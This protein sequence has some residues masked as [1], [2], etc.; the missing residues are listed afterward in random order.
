MATVAAAPVLAQ[1]ES[2]L[3][4]RVRGSAQ[5]REAPAVSR[6]AAVTVLERPVRL[7]AA[8]RQ[9]VP[10]LSQLISTDQAIVAE[11]RSRLDGGTFAA[12]QTAVARSVVTLPLDAIDPRLQTLMRQAAAQES[13]L[14]PEPSRTMLDDRD[15]WAGLMALGM[16][17]GQMLA[18][19][20]LRDRLTADLPELL[21][22]LEP[23]PVIAG[24][25]QRRRQARQQL[26]EARAEAA[27]LQLTSQLRL[28][29]RSVAEQDQVRREL[30]DALGVDERLARWRA[31]TGAQAAPARVWSSL[32]ELLAQRVRQLE[33][34]AQSIPGGAQAWT[35]HSRLLAPAGPGASR[36]G[37][38]RTEWR[39]LQADLRRAVREGA[40]AM[41]RLEPRL[42]ER[43]RL[44]VELSRQRS[45]GFGDGL[46]EVVEI[47]SQLLNWFTAAWR[48]ARGANEPSVVNA[49]DALVRRYEQ[50]SD[51]ALALEA[52]ADVEWQMLHASSVVSRLGADAGSQSGAAPLARLS[53]ALATLAPELAA[54]GK[55]VDDAE[56][57]WLRFDDF[58]D[59]LLLARTRV[60]DERQRAWPAAEAG[61]GLGSVVGVASGLRAVVAV[62]AADA[63]ADQQLRA[64]T[65]LAGAQ[66]PV[67]R[68]LW[69]RPTG[70]GW[71]Y[72]LPMAEF[73]EQ[74]LREIDA[75]Q[76][77]DGYLRTASDP[78]Q[79]GGLRAGAVISLVDLLGLAWHV[80]ADGDDLALLVDLNGATLAISDLGR[81]RPRLELRP[82]APHAERLVRVA[83][84]SL[85]GLRLIEVQQPGGFSAY[86]E[87]WTGNLGNQMSKNRLSYALITGV[88]VI[89]G[90]IAVAVFSAPLAAVA[91]A[92]ATALAFQF[93]K[94]E[95]FATAHTYV[96]RVHATPEAQRAAAGRLEAAEFLSNIGT[97]LWG[98]GHALLNVR[99]AVLTARAVDAARQLATAEPAAGA[100][101]QQA[102]QALARA[103]KVEGWVAALDKMARF[104]GALQAGSEASEDAR[105]LAGAVSGY[106]D[107]AQASSAFR[108]ASGLR[109]SAQT[110]AGEADDAARLVTELRMAAGLGA[111]GQSAAGVARQ[112]SGAN[113]PAQA[114][115]TAAG[116]TQ[117]VGQQG[118]DIGGT[119]GDLS[120]PVQKTLDLFRERQAQRGQ[121][122]AAAAAG[123]VSPAAGTTGAG[124]DQR[125]MNEQL[126]RQNA[127]L[128][129][130]R[131]AGQT[132]AT[133][134]A[135]P[136]KP[137]P[138]PSI[139]EPPRPEG[140][141]PSTDPPKSV[142]TPASAAAASAPLAGTT[143]VPVK[144]VAPA[145]TPPTVPDL[146]A[147]PSD[148][149]LWFTWSYCDAKGGWWCPLELSYTRESDLRRRAD[150]GKKVITIFKGYRSR[151]DALQGICSATTNLW[152]G[153]EF[154]CGI[155]GTVYGGSFCV[156][157]F[158][159]F[160]SATKA[161]SCRR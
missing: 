37:E 17:D 13:L 58:L 133:V 109:F 152:R 134:A 129:A 46:Q 153:G 26:A 9:L 8:M 31:R 20:D 21:E 146:I 59:H 149:M 49:A 61:P 11:L 143:P 116:E 92:G 106:R 148:E 84:G 35:L 141:K 132:P 157:E 100:A 150:L 83:G 80:R 51:V 64:D 123:V 75:G 14:G 86:L 130:W 47:E 19:V 79:P 78:G 97:G 41:E 135:T 98:G 44:L 15:L 113:R 71:S 117:H 160:D 40:A 25:A 73:I 70:R 67:A 63:R 139:V 1:S 22:S 7:R 34:L 107:A 120:E 12:N 2:S 137:P 72:A 54:F 27:R 60:W 29:L 56:A 53:A 128:Q 68:V 124:L 110:A 24:L 90:T 127:Q 112:L 159:L 158:V 125:S 151:D 89:G 147:K 93:V 62:R 36:S 77:L 66:D 131:A 95:I 108:W 122:G 87:R 88:G 154:S 111:T 99:E 105:R 142:A 104:R 115:A 161:T 65:R 145:P 3:A 16:Y 42:R 28:A 38:P 39:S 114:A 18:L 6:D 48:E 4:A 155:I 96:P 45:D 82:P 57:V 10:A 30:A 50:L 121:P 23:S 69:G 103:D 94:D 33:P 32:H 85:G 74:S 138:P 43:N 140:G 136:P 118:A 5:W 52:L 144:P 102:A 101:A 126:A 76:A 81:D 91:T 55:T 119:A 156:G